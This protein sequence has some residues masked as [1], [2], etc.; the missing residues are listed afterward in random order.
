M[1][2]HL[3]V[4]IISQ[5]PNL[6]YFHI[7]A[8][9]L[10]IGISEV[11][12]QTAMRCIL[13]VPVPSSTSKPRSST[14]EDT[15]QVTTSHTFFECCLHPT[16]LSGME[17]HEHGWPVLSA[18]TLSS[19]TR[20]PASLHPVMKL[21]GLFPP[22]ILRVGPSTNRATAVSDFL[23]GIGVGWLVL[24]PA[25]VFAPACSSAGPQSRG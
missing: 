18:V 23:L 13:K 21:F 10:S 12:K 14:R 5:R 17:G 16:G 24:H 19:K 22:S 3:H 2:F 20:D 25:A 11:Y 4:L 1:G 8:W 6:K 9:S 7:G 15:W